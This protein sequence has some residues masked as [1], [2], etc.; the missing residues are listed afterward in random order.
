MI[1]LYSLKGKKS[2][3]FHTQSSGYYGWTG[4][5]MIYNYLDSI[6]SSSLTKS[7]THP[8]PVIDYISHVLLPEAAMVLIAEDYGFN[9]D[10]IVEYTKVLEIM[11]RSE[12]WGMLMHPNLKEDHILGELFS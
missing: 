6:Y 7:S 3:E 2:L 8:L 1:D 10:L 11:D 5:S 12:E 4:T 9:L